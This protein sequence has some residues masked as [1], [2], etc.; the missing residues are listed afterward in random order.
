MRLEMKNMTENSQDEVPTSSSLVSDLNE[1]DS[2][3]MCSYQSTVCESDI[4]EA[5]L[6]RHERENQ[7]D[8][9]TVNP[10]G[11]QNNQINFQISVVNNSEWFKQ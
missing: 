3:S 1:F 11:S 6:R 4:V 8:V 2:V 10:V 9:D 5:R 7:S